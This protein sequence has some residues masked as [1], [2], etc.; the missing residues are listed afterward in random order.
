MQQKSS[1]T[2]NSDWKG[3]VRTLLVAAFTS[4]VATYLSVY[5]ID[6]YYLFIHSPSAKRLPI[7]KRPRHWKPGLARKQRFDSFI[8]GTSAVML[9]KP[10]RLNSLL[11]ARIAW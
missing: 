2:S 6:P 8:T 11:D 10:E 9:F 1:S 7:S 5:L 4:L 3:F